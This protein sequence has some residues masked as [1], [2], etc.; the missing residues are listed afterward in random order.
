MRVADVM[1]PRPVTVSV[2]CTTDAALRLL[3]SHGVTA[4]PVVDRAARLVGIV[5]EV[6]LIPGRI[7]ADPVLA[8]DRGESPTSRSQGPDAAVA[9]VMS[10]LIVVV[11]PETD[12]AEA[13]RVFQAHRFKSLPVLDAADQVV[14]MVSRSDVVR[15]LTRDDGTLEQDLADMLTGA[16]LL[17]F[18][19]TVRHGV[20]Q[21]RAT[22]TGGESDLDR[23][24][25][26]VQSTPGVRA[27]NVFRDVM[28]ETAEDQEVDRDD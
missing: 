26:I 9:D 23:A 5:S 17:G 19:V 27:V 18:P 22:G 21:L 15:T 28:V 8:G 12:L 3:G 4:L 7:P 1:T 25:T 10:R 14:G 11:H 2:D 6:D 13:G 20:V 16:G 24:L